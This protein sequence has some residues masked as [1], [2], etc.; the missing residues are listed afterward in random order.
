MAQTVL[1]ANERVDHF[2][3]VIKFVRSNE[4]YCL[5]QQTAEDRHLAPERSHR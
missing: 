1:Q 3:L 2:G 5:L 4:N